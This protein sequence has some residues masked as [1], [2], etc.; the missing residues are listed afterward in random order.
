MPIPFASRRTFTALLLAALCSVPVAA[1]QDGKGNLLFLWRENPPKGSADG[2]IIRHLQEQGYTVTT[3]EALDDPAEL[4]QYDLVLLSSTVRSNQMTE[5]RKLVSALR[6]MRVPL[7]TW[8]NDLL[9]DL[10]YT[11]LRRDSNFGELET[12]HYAWVVRAPHPLAAGVPAGLTTWTEARQ[13]AGWGT[14]GLGADTIMIWPGE[15]DKALYFAYERGA[16]MDHD[17]LAPARRIFLGLDNNTFTHL[18]DEGRKF[19]DAAVQWGV[20]GKDERSKDCIAPSPHS[21]LE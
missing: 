14:P 13:P 18:T 3:R 10:R 20:A 7:L 16:T 8:E 21:A 1:Q 4:C 19:F 17:F 11:A 12:G 6:N 2:D 5:G 15:P 9:D